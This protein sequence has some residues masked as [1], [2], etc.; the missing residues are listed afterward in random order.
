MNYFAGAIA[1][2]LDGAN[3]GGENSIGSRLVDHLV[4]TGISVGIAVLIAVPVGLLIGHT[5]RGRTIIVAIT[6]SVRA[7]PTLGLL[8]FVVLFTGLGLW[9]L[10]L[11][12]VVL[13][14][15][16]LLAGAYSGLDAIDRQT[17]DAARAI[18][19]TEWQILT[20]VE[21]P[22]GIGLIVGGLRSAALQVVATATVAG[23][24]GLTGLGR[25]LIEGLALHRYELAIVGAILVAALAI[26]VDLVLVGVQRL[27]VPRG[28]PRGTSRPR[29][30]G[31]RP[32]GPSGAPAPV[33][34]G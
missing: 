22:L 8:L 15:P 7:I 33:T 3:W 16:P 20:R 13:A 11:V 26:V 1:F 10:V 5:G 2:I 4:Y 24:V 18:G 27:V 14:I 23:Y 17:I 30:R 19:M 32:S 25:F 6:G 28:V 12:L 29:A 31:G 9:P 21:I 34:E